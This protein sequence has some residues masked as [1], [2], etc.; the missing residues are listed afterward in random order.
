MLRGLDQPRDHGSD[1]VVQPIL[2]RVADRDLGHRLIRPP[3]R[4]ETV[5]EP[6]ALCLGEGPMRC[7]ERCRCCRQI[8]LEAVGLRRLRHGAD[9]R[10]RVEHRGDLMA[11]VLERKQDLPELRA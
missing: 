11:E 1:L 7:V 8:E 4:R 6:K 10:Q 9:I 5:E 3:G 2:G